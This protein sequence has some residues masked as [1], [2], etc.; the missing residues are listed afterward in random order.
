M[1]PREDPMR[2]PYSFYLFS[3]VLLSTSLS[4][5]IIPGQ[6]DDFQTGAVLGWAGG[7]TVPP[8]HHPDGGPTGTGDGFLQITT[9]NF[10]LGA[11]NTAQWTGNYIAAGIPALEM[12]LNNFGPA[13]VDFRIVFFGPGGMFASSNRVSLAAGSGWQHAVYS[14]DPANLWYVSGGT[15]NPSDTLSDVTTLLIRNDRDPP[16]PQGSHPPHIT[17]TLGIDNIHALPEPGLSIIFFLVLFLR[18]SLIRDII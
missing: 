9:T 5:A 14:L 1:T 2:S 7:K 6:L 8:E 18:E 16:T 17:G 12:D 15:A 10:H 13:A 3:A 11:K 4:L